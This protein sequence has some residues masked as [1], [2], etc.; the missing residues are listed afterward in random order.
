MIVITCPSCGHINEL[1]T[2]LTNSLLHSIVAQAGAL[3]AVDANVILSSSKRRRVAQ[4]RAA[5][6]AVMRDELR[7]SY[8]DIGAA[9]G[10]DHSTCILAVRRADPA[11]VAQLTHAVRELLPA[12]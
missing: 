5:V 1:D 8:A 4:A 3:F 11:M 6:C 10:R 7:M 2:S 9:V 12:P